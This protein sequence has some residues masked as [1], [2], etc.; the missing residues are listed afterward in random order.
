MTWMLFGEQLVPFGEAMKEF[1]IAVTGLNADVVVNSVTAGKAL[2]ELANTVPNSGGLVAFFTGENDLD[3]FG[4]KLVPFGE[5]MKQYSI[6]VTGLDA[7]V[8]G[9]FA[10]KCGESSGRAV[11]QSSE[12]R[13]H[14]Q[15]VYG[16]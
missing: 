14:C 11:Q 9:K 6:A 15:L 1:S 7:N 5:A 3:M 12:Q 8:V 10:K 4:E 2:M 16:R 13:W